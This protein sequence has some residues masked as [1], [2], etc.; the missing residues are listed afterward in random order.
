MSL[1]A[2]QQPIEERVQYHLDR[3]LESEDVARKDYHIRTALQFL[4]I[5]NE[6]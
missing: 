1:K 3:A 5:D 6:R 2:N 4:G